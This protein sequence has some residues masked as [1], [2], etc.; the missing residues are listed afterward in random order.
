MDESKQKTIHMSYNSCWLPYLH[1][2]AVL[3]QISQEALWLLLAQLEG[4]LTTS[5]RSTLIAGFQL[6]PLEATLERVK[7]EA[8]GP[9]AI[10]ESQL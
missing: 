5:Q 6:K 4:I 9:D 3:S 2:K 10:S 7:L 1:I 8:Q